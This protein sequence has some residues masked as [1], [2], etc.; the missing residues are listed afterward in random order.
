[1]FWLVNILGSIIVGIPLLLGDIYYDHQNE[2][3]SIINFDEIITLYMRT[4]FVFA[5]VATWRSSRCNLY[6]YSKKKNFTIN[7]RWLF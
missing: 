1:M 4:Y 2:F 5:T 3:L 6:K 7:L